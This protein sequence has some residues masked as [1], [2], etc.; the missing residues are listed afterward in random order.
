MRTALKV[1]VLTD[2]KIPVRRFGQW[3]P[4]YEV[5]GKP[6]TRKDGVACVPVR[7][8]DSGEKLL[9][10]VDQFEKDPPA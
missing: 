4:V 7:V 8:L 6:R 2:E 5:T 1:D 3:G 10:P 9:Y